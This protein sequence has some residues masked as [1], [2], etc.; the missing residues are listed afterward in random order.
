MLPLGS[1][2]VCR[3]Y[4]PGTVHISDSFDAGNIICDETSVDA[5]RLR[6]KPDPYTAGEC[7]VQG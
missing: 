7:E 4:T 1:F 3:E 5:V 2:A 6:I